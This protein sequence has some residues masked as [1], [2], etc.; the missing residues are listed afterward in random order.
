MNKLKKRAFSLLAALL[1]LL[2]ACA[3]GGGGETE[4]PSA[5]ESSAAAQTEPSTE[6]TA[7]PTRAE[8]TE[9]AEETEPEDSVERFVLSFAG[10]CTFGYT[11][12]P[13]GSGGNFPSIVGTDYSYPLANVAQYFLNDDYT[14][15]NLE[16]CLTYY[17]PTEEEMESMGLATKRF[18]FKGLPA[19][20]QILSCSGVEFASCCNNHSL[21]FGWTGWSNTLS[22]LADVGVGYAG[23][24]KTWVA[25]TESGLTIGVAAYSFYV[26]EANLR[27]TIS[28][29]REQG[30]EVVII[31][32]HGGTEGSYS[33]TE[34]QIR[35]SRLAIDCGADIVFGHHTHT[36]LPVEYYG[37]GV[38]YYGLG[39]FSFAGNTYPSDM[40][41]AILQQEIL[42]A[43][44]GT[45][46]LGALT[47]IPCSMSS[48]TTQNNYQPTPYQTSDEGYD[49]ALSKLL[50]LYAGDDLY[51]SYRDDD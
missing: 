14:L 44:D 8:Q 31:S 5:Q 26:T 21:D 4:A 29:L 30:A 34:N 47:M 1:L 41:S 46:S 35:N 50:G 37:D 11:I 45:I 32:L 2:S 42:R 13:E 3:A 36:L 38:I 10:D 40:D 23:Y 51:V 18:R 49:R 20:A 6:A 48:I 27:S 16:C 9:P 43:Q 39:N 28:S 24:G 22:A 17:T 33:P 12:T 15:V 7:E 19:Y 25:T